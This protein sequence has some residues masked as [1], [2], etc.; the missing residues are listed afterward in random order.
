MP[1]RDVL[2]ALNSALEMS[3]NGRHTPERSA[4][5]E[6]TIHDLDAALKD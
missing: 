1:L 4:K 2:D 3:V 5:I 6:K